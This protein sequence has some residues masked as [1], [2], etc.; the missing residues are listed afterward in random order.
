MTDATDELARALIA[1]EQA[2]AQLPIYLPAVVVGA[3]DDR[4]MQ[5]DL[6]G[7]KLVPAYLPRTVG[8]CRTGQ[9]VRVRLQENTYTIAEVNSSIQWD[10]E[11]FTYASGWQDSGLASGQAQRCGW[12]VISGIGFVR[13]TLM[14]TG[15]AITASSTGHL[16]DFDVVTIPPAAVPVW[17]G[18][19]PL[20]W[21]TTTS[22]GGGM[23]DTTTGMARLTDLNSSSKVSTGDYIATVITYPLWTTGV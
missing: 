12:R 16:A 23:L 13:L 20:H 19:Y 5:V 8:Y 2:T 7:A 14:R 3:I 9:A 15:G 1:L 6:G 4:H 22:S 10:T 17:S 18:L 11:G 21:K